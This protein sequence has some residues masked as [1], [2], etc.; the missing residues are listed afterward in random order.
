MGWKEFTVELLG[1]ISWPITTIFVV[2][3][4]RSKLNDLLPRLESFKH[5]DT[6]LAFAKAMDKVTEQ[7]Y[8]I[9]SDNV[10]SDDLKNE[11]ERLLSLV[12]ISPNAV[13]HQS[14]NLVDIKLH[15]IYNSILEGNEREPLTNGKAAKLRKRYGINKELEKKI[16]QIK[17]IRLITIRNFK[18]FVSEEQATSFIELCI[19]IIRELD[20]QANNTVK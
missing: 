15:D 3:L 5:K 11:E 9:S 20:E 6:E 16:I 19:D 18:Q 13:L 10:L 12:D 2:T 4:L 14:Y 1:N 7:V 8:E 17:Q